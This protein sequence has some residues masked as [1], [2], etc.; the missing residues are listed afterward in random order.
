MEKNTR[1]LPA[2]RR[3]SRFALLATLALLACGGETA[4]AGADAHTAGGAT[5]DAGG[6]FDARSA[7]DLGSEG[8]DAAAG[9]DP[10]DGVPGAPPDGAALYVEMC[11]HCHGPHGEGGGGPPLTRAYQRD[12]L[13]EYIDARM[14][15]GNPERCDAACAGALADYILGAL[16]GTPP[17]DCDAPVPGPRALRLL[18][19]REYRNT[20][21]DLLR[22]E[23]NESTP[24]GRAC[25]SL[26]DCD[27][28]RSSCTDAVCVADPCAVHT[29]LF[30]AAGRA[31]SSVHVSGS[32]NGWPATVAA[33][34]WPLVFE[35][36]LNRWV[37]K[38]S[39]PDG[40]HSYKLVLDEREWLADPANPDTAPDGFGGQN[41]VLRQHCAEAG[42]GGE[43]SPGGD[44][45]AG[46]LAALTRDLPPETRPRGFGFETHASAGVATSVHV[47]AWLEAAQTVAAQVAALPARFAPCLGQADCPAQFLADFGRRAFRR[48]LTAAEV[49]R[50][51]ELWRAQADDTQGLAATVEALL[52]SPNFLYRSEL[53]EAQPDGT[54]RLTADELAGALSYGFWATMPDDE[55]LTAAA[56]GALSTP[57]GL[58]RE[59]RRLLADPRARDQIGEFALQWL[60]IDALSTK[61]R[62]ADLYPAWDEALARS[63]VEESRRFVESAVFEPDA[64]FDTLI[65]GDYTFVNDRLAAL[66]GLPGTF[67]AAFER[68]SLA[69]L[70]NGP[71][72]GVLGHASVLAATA[73]SDQTSPIR[74]GLFVRERLLCTIFGTPPADAG[75]VPEVDPSATTR[76][77]FRQ[78]T[79]EARCAAC[80]RYI[81]DLGFGFERF[82]AI[83]AYREA[84]AGQPIDARGNLNDVEGLGTGT[85]AHFETLPALA[86]VLAESERARDCFATQIWRYQRGRLETP[87][88]ACDLGDVQARFRAAG[89]DLRSLLVGVVLTPAFSWRRDPGEAA[90]AGAAAGDG[91]R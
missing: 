55:L 16:L 76:E 65:R 61:T 74:R 67:G 57:E 24:V 27:A 13:A 37:L 58:E 3:P 47:S 70:A 28:Q 86:G 90:E 30:D 19:R 75:G 88:D 82:D 39:V 46:E 81:D 43:I 50:Y 9:R 85:D 10:D 59:A 34:G 25:A 11:T 42:A 38:Q 7:G 62:R 36:S 79:A 14:P 72:A 2:A 60:G 71:R 83:G 63:M 48:T 40:D 56:A 68:T 69:G 52:S 32:F 91:G 77:R 87:A 31:L 1:A 44:A 17:P 15:L 49:T 80:H 54:F 33:G 5:L 23:A 21:R 73:H 22:L 18:T 45:L 64:G 6:A 78:H 51:T 20:I 26:A 12:Y 4:D 84:E 8:A 89:G 35:A 29:F 53:G 66:Y 41:S